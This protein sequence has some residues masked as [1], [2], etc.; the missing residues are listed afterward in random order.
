M[1]KY[2]YAFDELYALI[3]Y[4]VYTRYLCRSFFLMVYTISCVVVI[5]HTPV[6][7][8]IHNHPNHK[9]HNAIACITIESCNCS[10]SPVCCP[11]LLSTRPQV[12]LWLSPPRPIEDLHWRKPLQTNGRLNRN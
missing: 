2:E 9:F 12:H 5:R 1:N 8:T 3:F 10:T 6:C 4:T 7:V 11:W